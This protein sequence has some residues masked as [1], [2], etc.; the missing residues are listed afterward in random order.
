MSASPP[1]ADSTRL[2]AWKWSGLSIVA[3]LGVLAAFARIAADWEWLVPL[4]DSV[5]RTGEVPGRVAFAASSTDGW[6]NVPVLAQLVASVVDD[7][8]GAMG[9]VV[10]HLVSVAA[11][12]VVLTASA[13]HLGASDARTAGLLVAVCVGAMPA[14]ALVRLQ[15]FSLALFA[16]LVSLVWHQ[17]RRPS[18]HVWWLPV[19]VAAWGNLHGAVLLGVCVAGAYLLFGR[20]RERPR[21]TVLVGLATLASLCVTPQG[22]RTVSYYASVLDNEAAARGEGLWARPELGQPFDVMMLG[23]VAVLSLVGLRYR[24]SVWEYVAVLGLALATAEAA[25]HGVWLIF[26]LFMVA[27]VPPVRLEEPAPAQQRWAWRPVVLTSAV[28]AFVLVPILSTRGLSVEA[29]D[30]AVVDAVV[31][32]A[33]TDVV[34]APAPLVESLAASGVTVWAGN[35]L[36][37][38][39]PEVQIAYLDFL[40]GEPGMALAVEGSDL[41]VVVEGG[42]AE[43]GLL[44]LGEDLERQDLPGEYVAYRRP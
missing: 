26:V 30:P 8:G 41:V 12:L 33:G 15:S 31:T 2:S 39:A 29:V 35:P 11:A 36:D 44:S 14:L 10:L 3:C 18:R 4:G 37:A 40:A 28:S 6:Q 13:R 20:L 17:S 22:W 27:A 42:D 1:L 43:E 32:G 23:A 34:L 19:L 21:E 24:R 25:R 9:A 16:L 7:L 38:F 5:R